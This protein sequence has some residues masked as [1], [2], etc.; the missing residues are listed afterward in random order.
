MLIWRKVLNWD[1]FS[2]QQTVSLFQLNLKQK[3]KCYTVIHVDVKSVLTELS[4]FINCFLQMHPNNFIINEITGLCRIE[5]SVVEPGK[6][7]VFTKGREIGQKWKEQI[8][9]R[10]APAFRVAFTIRRKLNFFFLFLAMQALG[11]QTHGD[12]QVKNSIEFCFTL[13]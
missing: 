12:M 13:R 2:F 7:R 6:A 5:N 1:K 3:I 8:M 9:H 10:K 11:G 4:L